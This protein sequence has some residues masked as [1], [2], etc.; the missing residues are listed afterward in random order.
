MARDDELRQLLTDFVSAKLGESVVI[1]ELTRLSGGASREMWSFTAGGRRMVLRREPPGVA[2]LTE[3]SPEVVL[4][5]RATAAGVP[6]PK[7]LWTATAEE[8]GS[9]GFVMEHVDGETIARR[10]L[11]EDRYAHARSVMA[12]QCGEI[13]AKIQT[14]PTDGLEMPTVKPADAVLDQFGGLLRSLGEPHPVFELALRWLAQRKPDSDR[15]V[16]VHGDFRNGNFIV[17]EEGI[18]AVLDWEIAHAGDPCEDLAWICC[19]SWRFG[20]AGEVGGFGEREDLYAGYEEASGIR[21]DPDAV[22]WWE[23]MSS[24][25]WGIMTILQAFTHLSGSRNSLEHAAIGRRTV[26][27]EWDVLELIRDARRGV[28]IR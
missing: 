17:G 9:P 11:R 24:V 25:K 20:E 22:R 10:I 12:K 18:R 27:T 28:G 4:L 2:P 1:D 8:L 5:Q 14:M 3:R 13:V 16:M 23:I 15:I 26:E 19:R 6:V 7:V 21:V